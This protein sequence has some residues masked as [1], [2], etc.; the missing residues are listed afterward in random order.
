MWS[1]FIEHLKLPKIYIKSRLINCQLISSLSDYDCTNMI[2]KLQSI[3]S[4]DEL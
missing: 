1:A 3:N 2:S 4:S